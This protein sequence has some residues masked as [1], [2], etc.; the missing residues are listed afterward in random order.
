M[1][2]SVRWQKQCE[3]IIRE[4]EGWVRDSVKILYPSKWE[5]RNIIMKT[6]WRRFGQWAEERGNTQQAVGTAE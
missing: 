1:V 2:G 6:G 3:E 4:L 5:N